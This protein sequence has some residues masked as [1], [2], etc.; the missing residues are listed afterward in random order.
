MGL[1]EGAAGWLAGPVAHGRQDWQEEEQRAAQQMVHPDHDRAYFINDDGQR[2]LAQRRPVPAQRPLIG[3]E[4]AALDAMIPEEIDAARRRA[5]RR[6]VQQAFRIRDR[7]DD[8]A[9]EG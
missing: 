2:V 3:Q 9:N 7:E 5:R 8:F 1:N 4:V 6:Q